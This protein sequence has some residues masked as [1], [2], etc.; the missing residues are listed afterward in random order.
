MSNKP[1]RTSWYGEGTSRSQ[2]SQAAETYSEILLESRH[3]LIHTDFRSSYKILRAT[4]LPV[5]RRPITID[6]IMDVLTEII[7]HIIGVLV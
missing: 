2:S 6:L 7:V 1:C 5:L 4:L 3:G